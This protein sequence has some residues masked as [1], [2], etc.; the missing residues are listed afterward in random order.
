[1]SFWR[2][3]P[4]SHLQMSLYG[5]SGLFGLLGL[6]GGLDVIRRTECYLFDMDKMFFVSC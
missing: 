4:G 5:L 1:M 6:S 3:A 2:K